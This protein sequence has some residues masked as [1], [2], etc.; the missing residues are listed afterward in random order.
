MLELLKVVVFFQETRG[1]LRSVCV[2][3]ENTLTP[4]GLICMR[5]GR[6]ARIMPMS[7]ILNQVFL[8]KSMEELHC[9]ELLWASYLISYRILSDQKVRRV[10]SIICQVRLG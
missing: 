3:S 1:V 10:S 6:R 2:R 7:M 9:E 4:A 8:C 5:I